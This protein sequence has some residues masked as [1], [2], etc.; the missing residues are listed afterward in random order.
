MS[1]YTTQVRHICETASGLTES[2]GFDN[3]P[4]VIQKAIPNVFNFTFPIFDEAYRVPLETKILTHFYTR[5]IGL[6]TVGLWKLKLYTKLN[7]IMPY[8][9]QLYKSELIKFNPMYDVDLTRAHN[10]GTKGNAG[11]DVTD[12]RDTT[13][14][15]H[16]T[17]TGN[18][19]NTNTVA[20]KQFTSDTPQGSLTDLETGKYMTQ[21]NI[22]NDTTTNVGRADTTING[23]SDSMVNGTTK[24]LSNFTNTEDYLESVQGKQGTTSYSDMLLKFRETFLNIDM[25]IIDE[26]EEL[27]FGLWD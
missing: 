14:N 6:E 13:N 10:R 19:N 24:E 21:G 17:T 1:R 5:M 15:D 25:L 18:T 3:I 9:N 22:N 23:I 8:Y 7:E 12:K 16:T 26:L 4:D 20:G 27:F 2:V 11:R